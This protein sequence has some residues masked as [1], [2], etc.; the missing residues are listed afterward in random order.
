MRN[1]F[2]VLFFCCFSFFFTTPL[3]AKRYHRLK[4]F[5]AFDAKKIINKLLESAKTAEGARGSHRESRG[6]VGGWLSSRSA[7]TRTVQ[8]D[9]LNSA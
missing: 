4:Y 9:N 1:E 8:F 7:L 3:L 6:L 5:V 2:C